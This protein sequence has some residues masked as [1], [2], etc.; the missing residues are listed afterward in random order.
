LRLGGIHKTLGTVAEGTGI[1]AGV[2][3]NALF[4]LGNQIGPS[5]FLIEGFESLYV[6]E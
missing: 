6:E 2:A 5:L 4:C 3:A 1:A